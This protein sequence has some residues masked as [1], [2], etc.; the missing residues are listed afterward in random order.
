MKRVGGLSVAIWVFSS[1]AIGSPR[2]VVTT[3]A[4]V[5]DCLTSVQL[6]AGVA[7]AFAGAEAPPADQT[8]RVSISRADGGGLLADV[9]WT[10]EA[11][12]TPRRALESASDDCRQLNDAIPLVARALWEAESASDASTVEPQ[13]AAPCAP[14]SPPPPEP[15]LLPAIVRAEAAPPRDTVARAPAARTPLQVAVGGAGVLGVLDQAALGV[16]AEVR[17]PLGRSWALRLAATRLNDGRVA[18]VDEGR[19][20][21]SAITGRAAGCW[22]LP[23]AIS[24]DACLGVDAGALL[25]QLSQVAGADQ[26]ARP[27]LWPIALLASRLTLIGPLT[28]QVSVA[29]GPALIRQDFYLIDARGDR[30]AVLRAPPA[31]LEAG[32]SLG[33]ELQ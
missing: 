33:V 31:L 13:D 28:A 4:G 14:A 6:A 17:V 9:R 8:L 12:E 27:L 10:G 1:S 19:A 26:A 29:T 24:V 16:R 20:R 3:E 23:G 21:F 11:R 22:V 30:Q 18:Q 2:A 7:S 15:R 32:L 25:P 5:T